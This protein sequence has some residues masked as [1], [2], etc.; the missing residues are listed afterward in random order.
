[1][2]IYPA[3]DIRQG[4]C[5][6]LVQ[7]SFS[8]VTVYSDD[9]MQ[10]AKKWEQQGAEYI[11]LVDL[12]GALSG[13]SINNEVIRKIAKAVNIP[14]QLG[15]GIRSIETIQSLLENGVT[16]VI[17]GTA[18]VKNPLLVKEAVERYGDQIAI[19]IDAKDGKA[20]V[21]GWEEV[22]DITA[23]GLALKMQDIGVKTII[24]TDIA[25]DGMLQGPNV[26]AMREMAG[27]LRIDVIASGGVSVLEDVK[28]LV[29]TGVQGAI[30][31]KAL[32][33][34]NISLPEA[35]CAAKEG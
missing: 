7:G 12:D 1:M 31:G 35:L 28:R 34:E 9:P 19:G 16:R 5:V 22:S 8:D 11:H 24:Y 18:A 20:A 15:G 27:S 13:Q 3:I 10:M 26:D 33:V 32:Y 4:K 30:I 25:K 29:H 21:D 23:L 6:R 17:L 2:V 14:V